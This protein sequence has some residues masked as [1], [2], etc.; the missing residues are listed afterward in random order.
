MLNCLCDDPPVLPLPP[1]LPS[2]SLTFM[3]FQEAT[4]KDA[5]YFVVNVMTAMSVLLR[6][7]KRVYSLSQIAA[8]ALRLSFILGQACCG[9]VS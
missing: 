8:S 5:K 3:Q 9:I 6:L 1:A 4:Q 7:S 2:H